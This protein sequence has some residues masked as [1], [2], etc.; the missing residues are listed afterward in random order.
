MEKGQDDIGIFEN[1]SGSKDY[2]DFLQKLGWIVNISEHKGFLGG[3]DPKITGPISP[4]WASFDV[5]VMFQVTTLMPNVDNK[6]IHKSRLINNN[7]VLISWV[8]DIDSYKPPSESTYNF[9]I[10]IYPLPSK[11][12]LIKLLVRISE[13]DQFTYVGPLLDNLVVSKHILP[14]LVRETCINANKFLNEDK[15][16]PFTIRK[17]LIEDFIQRHKVEQPVHHFL[18]AQFA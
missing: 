18:A 13:S 8:E 5:E 2:H 12:F 9:N 14:F 7:R 1:E 15:S 6:Q 11:L 17:L 3:L 4:Y 16:K 10:V